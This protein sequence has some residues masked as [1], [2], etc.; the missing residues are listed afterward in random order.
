MAAKGTA[1]PK[2][3]I[4]APNPILKNS[5]RGGGWLI[6]TPARVEMLVP[7]Q[8][9]QIWTRE[10]KSNWTAICRRSHGPLTGATAEL[11]WR[12]QQS[13]CKYNR[14]GQHWRQGW[15]HGKRRRSEKKKKKDK[16]HFRQRKERKD[17]QP[18]PIRRR[19]QRRLVW[20]FEA[21]SVHSV[22]LQSLS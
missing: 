10:T 14:C 17:K 3:P 6:S 5:A 16:L 20:R 21:G 12:H 11:H 4:S 1:F 15:D 19:Q 22:S 9:L 13:S 8:T 2:N 18:G 7:Y